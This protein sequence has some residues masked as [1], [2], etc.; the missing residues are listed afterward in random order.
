MEIEWA[1]DP[2]TIYHVSGRRYKGFLDDT[3]HAS[4]EADYILN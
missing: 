3:Q 4:Y 1:S 2:G